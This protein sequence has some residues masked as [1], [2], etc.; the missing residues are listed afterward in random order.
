MN[1]VR[2]KRRR[3]KRITKSMIKGGKN[4]RKKIYN[5]QK[6]N[7]VRTRNGIQ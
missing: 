2:E 1:G 7:M 5:Y 3:M 6:Y 4:K